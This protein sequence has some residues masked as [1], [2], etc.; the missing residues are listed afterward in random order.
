LKKIVGRR[1]PRRDRRNFHEMPDHERT[2]HRNHSGIYL[3][4]LRS[5]HTFECGQIVNRHC[6]YLDAMGIDREHRRG[7]NSICFPSTGI[8]LINESAIFL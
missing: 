2:W 5:G 6:D 3:A 7:K 4:L 1:V 8:D